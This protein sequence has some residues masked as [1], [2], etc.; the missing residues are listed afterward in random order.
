MPFLMPKHAS[1][2]LLRLQTVWRKAEP[3][4]DIIVFVIVLLA[5]NWLWKLT[6]NGDETGEGDVTFLGLVLTPFFDYLAQHIAQAAY[7]LVSWLRDTVHL[8]GTH[9]WFDSGNGTS[10]AWS[11]TPVKQ[12]FIW[13]WL[14]LAARGK[15]VH[16]LWFIPLGWLIIYGINILRIVAISLIIEFHPELFD[17]MHTYVFKYA[18]YGIMF[19]LWLAWTTAVARR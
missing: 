9:L 10:I 13:F 18:F 14:I 4:R 8:T 11:C 15:W 1:D 17:L 7:V 2:I 6:V 12:S 16:K 3:Y 19:L 5:A